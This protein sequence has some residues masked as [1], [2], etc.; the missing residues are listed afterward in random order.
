[1][2][3]PFNC[4][5]FSLF[6]KKRQFLLFWNLNSIPDQKTYEDLS[7]LGFTWS[8]NDYN[9]SQED[10]SLLKDIINKIY[11][12]LTIVTTKDYYY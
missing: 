8:K 3:Y 6:D 9:W 2:L 11:K 10:I 1:M 4:Y 5:S 7:L 12:K